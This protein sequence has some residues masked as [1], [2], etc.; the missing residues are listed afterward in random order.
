MNFRSLPALGLADF[1]DNVG[2]LLA[3]T[4]LAAIDS[5]VRTDLATAVGTLPDT[6]AT[7]AANV[8]TAKA[9]AKAAVSERNATIKQIYAL[10]AQVRDALQAGIAP[11]EQYDLAGF[12]G[13]PIRS[14]SFIPSD[15]TNLAVV[16]ASNGVNTGQFKG[17]NRTGRV[18]YEI[19]RREGDTGGWGMLMSTSKQKFQDTPVRPGQYYEY[20]V[21]ARAAKA[22]SNF[23]NSSVV[24]GAV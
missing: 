19:W 20:K 7:Q 6:L 5:N 9:A 4:Q 8:E 22:I 16:G 21:R 23:S 1:A 2:T 3:G 10:M 11:Q 18:Q 15:P 17:N 24:Y 14:G 12:E 13:P